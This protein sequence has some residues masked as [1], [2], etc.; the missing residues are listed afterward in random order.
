MNKP[1][2]IDLMLRLQ[3]SYQWL[4]IA[5]DEIMESGFL[6]CL[7]GLDSTRTFMSMLAY[8]LGGKPN[9]QEKLRQEI[10][11]VFQGKE[12]VIYDEVESLRYL[13]MVL[14]ETI[15]LHPPVRHIDKLCKKNYQFSSDFRISAG[16]VVKISIYEMHRNSKY[17]PD[18]E[19]FDPER[20]RD[21]LCPR[22]FMPFG[23]GPGRCF[24]EK[25]ALAQIKIL[26][27]HLIRNFEIELLE[28]EEVWIKLKPRKNC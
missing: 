12:N 2:L 25:F 20:F 3:S 7:G 19:K 26:F 15:R 11:A 14:K 10:E 22:G 21:G 4:G 8:E 23:L 9:V 17:F 16:E 27:V 18:P 13:G 1:D 28:K 24:G 6:F 5:V